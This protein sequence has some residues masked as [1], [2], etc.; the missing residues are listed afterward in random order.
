MSG[1][2]NI[3]NL[4]QPLVE[5]RIR[6][7]GAEIR[8]IYRSI[9]YVLTAPDFDKS[10]GGQ[11]FVSME[12]DLVGR[13]AL[14]V[15]NWFR[16]NVKNAAIAAGMTETDAQLYWSKVYYALSVAMP[17]ITYVDASKIDA[18]I[19]TRKVPRPSSDQMDVRNYTGIAAAAVTATAGAV[20]F[21][22]LT[23]N[24]LIRISAIVGSGLAGYWCSS[25]IHAQEKR[26]IGLSSRA[27]EAE[28]AFIDEEELNRICKERTENIAECIAKWL[29]TG[30]ELAVKTWPE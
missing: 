7:S 19:S 1:T 28:V 21:R 6:E 30:Y 18:I 14:D 22:S 13:V 17:E 2:T 5:D 27:M 23:K 20:L 24:P 8:E 9:W 26:N 16:V 11:K 15:E 4:L 25:V 10:F 29:V 12:K 3:G